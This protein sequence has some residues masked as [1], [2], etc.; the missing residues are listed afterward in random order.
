MVLLLHFA[1]GRKALEI[2]ERETKKEQQQFRAEAV[3]G[4]RFQQV[5]RDVDVQTLEVRDRIRQTEV[6][7]LREQLEAQTQDWDARSKEQNE[8]ADKKLEEQKLA[9]AAELK[10]KR[11]ETTLLFA[12]ETTEMKESMDNLLRQLHS[13][14]VAYSIPATEFG[15]GNQ[16]SE[17]SA[18][19]QLGLANQAKV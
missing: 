19:D 17:W 16:G 18:E 10:K 5:Q 15:D 2:V 3:E 9:A 4:F 12:Q 14:M 11:E 6:L 13:Q 8:N 1:D 7:A